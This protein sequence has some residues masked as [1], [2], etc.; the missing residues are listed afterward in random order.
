MRGGRGRGAEGADGGGPGGGVEAGH[1]GRPG[2]VERGWIGRG[3][4]GVVH[5]VVGGEQVG[6][7]QVDQGDQPGAELRDPGIA[8]SQGTA[9]GVPPVKAAVSITMARVIITSW[10]R[11]EIG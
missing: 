5:H 10:E 11:P 1:R 4:G 8:G 7:R 9:A 2:R 6:G 3:R